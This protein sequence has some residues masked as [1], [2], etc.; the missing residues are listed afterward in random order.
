MEGC[1][2]IEIR[3]GKF[4]DA[5]ASTVGGFSVHATLGVISQLVYVRLLVMYF[6]K[7]IVIVQSK[8]VL[9]IVPIQLLFER[10]SYHS[11]QRRL[12]YIFYYLFSW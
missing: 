8:N 6:A 4:Y 2:S 12:V 5:K 3:Y 10:I 7:N 1:Y 11:H 9:L